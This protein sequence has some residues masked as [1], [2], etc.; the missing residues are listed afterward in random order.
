MEWS[1]AY[2]EVRSGTVGPERRRLFIRARGRRRPTGARNPKLG[3][4]SCASYSC[5]AAETES[6]L[7]LVRVR[8][9]V[10]G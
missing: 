8:T 10:V 1:P 7:L 2:V 3:R 6:E 4:A 5:A 9:Q